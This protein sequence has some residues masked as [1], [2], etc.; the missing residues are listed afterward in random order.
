MLH[1]VC[2]ISPF[3]FISL[4]IISAFGFVAAFVTVVVVVFNV[5]DGSV[6]D[7]DS[8]CS[9]LELLLLLW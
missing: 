9:R 5:G 8:G 6:G 4:C 1:S 3:H 2:F 7:G